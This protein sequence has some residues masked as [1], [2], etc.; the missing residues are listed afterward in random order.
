M[1][2][3]IL[4][5]FFIV[6]LFA[7]CSS[8]GK[9]AEAKSEKLIFGSGGG[10]TGMYKSFE[11]H[12]DG[13]VFNSLPDNSQSRV[14]KLSKKHTREIFMQVDKLKLNHPS[15]N[16]PGNMTWFIK[17]YFAGDST[18]FKWGESQF[19]VPNEIKDFY[20]QLNTIVK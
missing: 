3:R 18:E 13:R 14:K 8:T 15:F 17:Y 19:S 12:Q 7:S 10:F 4:L 20:T 9:V 2:T 5:S 6:T 16:H 1:I 11:I